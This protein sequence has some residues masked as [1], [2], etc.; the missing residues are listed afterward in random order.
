MGAKILIFLI[1][2]YKAYDDSSLSDLV[3][4]PKPTSEILIFLLLYDQ[5]KKEQ[6]CVVNSEEHRHVIPSLGVSVCQAE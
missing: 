1:I 3:K 5:S 4:K 6:N 2:L